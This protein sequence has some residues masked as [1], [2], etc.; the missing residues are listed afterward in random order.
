MS[1]EDDWLALN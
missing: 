1:E